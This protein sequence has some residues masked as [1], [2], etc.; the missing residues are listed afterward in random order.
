MC[1]CDSGL[2]AVDEGINSHLQL[3]PVS[4]L[5]LGGTD[6]RKAINVSIGALRCSHRAV[7]DVVTFNNRNERIVGSQSIT[8]SVFNLAVHLRFSHLQM[9]IFTAESLSNEQWL[10]LLVKGKH[11]SCR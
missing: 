9:T 2:D 10:Q 5:F 1:N 3:L 8:S 6:A 11:S 4:E 7:M